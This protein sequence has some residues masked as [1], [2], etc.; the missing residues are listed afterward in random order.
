MNPMEKTK[1]RDGFTIVEVLIVMCI[2][3]VGILAVMTLQ[4][5]STK[6]N[7]TARWITDGTNHLSDRF[8]H[9]MS[10]DYDDAEVGVGVNPTD[11]IGRY[12]VSYEVFNGPIPNTKRIDINVQLGNGRDIDVTYYKADTF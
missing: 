3:S 6:S 11:T 10:R 8:E 5:T 9:I 4:I 1:K 12:T 7:S 2:L